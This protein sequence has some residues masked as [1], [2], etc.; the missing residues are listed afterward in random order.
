MKSDLLEKY[1]SS[2]NLSKN[3]EKETKETQKK[4]KGEK[5]NKIIYGVNPSIKPLHAGCFGETFSISSI[6]KSIFSPPV[7]LFFVVI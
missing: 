6:S 4:K 2:I 3:E 1:P 5:E 7:L